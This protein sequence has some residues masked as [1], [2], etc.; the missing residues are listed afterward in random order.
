[1]EMEAHPRTR[2]QTIF[3]VL[4]STLALVSLLFSCQALYLERHRIASGYGD[5]VIFYTG[6]QIVRDG[7]ANELYDLSRQREYQDRFN[8]PIRAG[9]LP[10]NHPAYELLWHIPL[11]F[12]SYIDA[13]IVWNVINVG[14]LLGMARWF[15]PRNRSDLRLMFLL[16]MF[17]FYPVLV[18][19]LH[20]QD[21]ILLTYLIGAA[22][23]ALKQ[24]N[25]VAA[26]VLLALASFK[27]QLVLPIAL[28]WACKPYQKAAAVWL[29]SVTLLGIISVSMVG[30]PGAM[31]YLELISSINNANYTINPALMPNI[32]GMVYSS[33][34]AQFPIAVFPL[35][36][37][38]T[39]GLLAYI[40]RLWRRVPCEN[41]TISDLTIALILTLTTLSSY[42]AYTHDF[43]LLLLPALIVT[44]YLFNDGPPGTVPILLFAMLL[45]LWIPFPFAYGHL[46]QK[47]KLAWGS[48]VLIAFAV[49]LAMQ[50]KVLRAPRST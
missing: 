30:I 13:Y 37:L 5:Y 28:S 41:A 48:L 7:A 6:A 15:L 39:L 4:M 32:R 20:G 26:G 8:V 10:F 36:A 19:F 38:L 42:H 29:V 40:V 45:V 16:M 25:E 34:A 21:S 33:L 11:T 44:R 1:M 35:T 46:L 50:L 24:H 31:K 2:A 12:L 17:G 27:P 14:L 23:I 18:V 47:E 22:F 43:A 3:F 49:L 9:A